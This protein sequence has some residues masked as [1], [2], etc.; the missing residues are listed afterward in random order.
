MSLKSLISI[1]VAL[2]LPLAAAEKPSPAE[3]MPRAEDRTQLWWEEG[4]PKVFSI[5]SKPANEVLCFA[6]G[7]TVLRFDT[8]RVRP[9]EGGWE[10]AV[11]ENGRRFD[12]TGYAATNDDFFQPVRFVE[13]GRF[14]QRVVIEGLKFADSEGREWGGKARLEIS[15]WP[16]RLA[17]RLESESDA[18]LLLRFETTRRE[19]VKSVA[20][21]AVNA[22][23]T[24]VVESELTVTRDETL[25]CHRLALPDKPWSNAGGT[26][27]PEEHLDRLDRWRVTLRNDGDSPAVARLM[28]TQEK[29]LPI[30]GFTP[31]LCDPDGVPTGIP[32]QLSK[33]WHTR[34]EK[35]RVPHDGQW[36][37]GFAWV[38]VPPKS[39][40]DFVFQMVYARY[41]GV[42]AASH[43]QLSLIGWAHNQFWDQAAV[44]SF[45]ESICFEP[46]RV[47]RR[48][49]ITDVRPL[50][51]L[52]L[53]KPDAKRWSWAENCGGGDFLVWQ[54]PQGRF[55]SMKGTRTDYRAHGPCL[56][57]VGYTEETIGGEITARMDVSVPAANDHLRTFL[58]MRY[59]VKKPVRWQRLALFQLG[60]DF[61][62]TVPARKIAVGNRDGPRE[63]W[64]APRAKDKYDRT[65]LPLTGDAP[66]VSVHGVEREAISK[67]NAAAT[68][69]III[70]GW[71][72]VLGGKPAAP[73][74]STFCNEWGKGNHR[75]AVE[76]AT[77]PGL[78]ELQPGDFVEAELELVVFPA[79]AVAYYGPDVA[80]KETL[81]RDAD[82]WRPVHREAAGNH[83]TP[84]AKLGTIAKPYPLVIAVNEA[85][86]AQ[87]TVSGGIGHLPVTFT[88]LTAP[89]GHR[90]LANGKPIANWQTDWN[91]ATQRWQLTCN[92][93]TSADSAL[94]VSL[95]PGN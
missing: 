63:E 41:G 32:V 42:C 37:H 52:P 50:M 1:L 7:D 58:R 64:E 56:T 25:G 9:V 94:E 8:R 19:G 40:R 23:A 84:T 33:N 20:L 87:A 35:G 72:A 34:V 79:D 17:F 21:E 48:S 4:A 75:T 69:G 86:R 55:Q 38:R 54:D 67:G 62:N 28:F 93:P 44:G 12:C 47:Q 82:T 92:I 27:Y 90:I 15:V 89:R 46:G 49:F 80:L 29:H 91:P 76:L 5:P 18:T 77:P 3:W 53:N 61:Y 10:C 85:Q 73:H 26:F 83:L 71:R 59:D 16:D 36:F 39:K 11:I 65:S 51:T 57:D 70:R 45:G 81:A 14:F 95:E 30:T 74:L 43:A 22:P 66:W 6:R 88:G 68:R 2:F 78:A 31:M 13:S 60:A 24:A